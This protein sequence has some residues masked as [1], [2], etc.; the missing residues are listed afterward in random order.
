VSVVAGET[1]TLKAALQGR[2]QYE[3]LGEIATPAPP[4]KPPV[5]PSGS[6]NPF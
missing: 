2:F 3:V 5:K 6:V 1:A 4:P